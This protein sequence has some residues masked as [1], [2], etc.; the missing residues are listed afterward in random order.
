LSGTAK[1]NH[2]RI[3]IGRSLALNFL[4]SDVHEF[5]RRFLIHVLPTGFH[6]IRQYTSGSTAHRCSPAGLP[7]PA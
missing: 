5:I 3:V 6:S 2:D 7:P 4:G 1:F